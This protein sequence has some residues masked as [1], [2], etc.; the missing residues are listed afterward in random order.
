MPFS[1][2]NFEKI[3][4]GSEKLFRIMNPGAITVQRISRSVSCQP[5]LPV[6]ANVT[7]CRNTVYKVI[8]PGITSS[9]TINPPEKWLLRRWQFAVT[10][11]NGNSSGNN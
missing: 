6:T 10:L 1:Y 5:R 3:G 4:L 8:N 7:V 2:L 11:Y 9:R